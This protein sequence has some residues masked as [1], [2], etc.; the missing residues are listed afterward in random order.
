[1]PAPAPSPPVGP[2]GPPG[3]IPLI[4]S[5]WLAGGSGPS[6][7]STSAARAGPSAG[8]PRPCRFADLPLMAERV[9]DPPDAPAVLVLHRRLCSSARCQ[10]H[11][12]HRVRI[13][14]DEQ[15][16]ARPATDRPGAEAT[17]ARRWRANPER[18]IA[19]PELGDDVIT[20]ADAVQDPSAERRPVEVHRLGGRLNPQLRL[21][22]HHDRN[23]ARR[24][25]PQVLA[26]A[27]SRRGQLSVVMAPC[28]GSLPAGSP[29]TGTGRPP[30]G[31]P[32]TPARA[33][34]QT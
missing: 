20:V 32:P 29:C 3:P 26:T 34:A 13:V 1:M 16:P 10:R 2:L 11:P 17:H 5:Q 23:C 28:P 18:S 7:R 22:A 6:P 33:G 9:N 15:R 8:R 14:H 27:R 12:H 25:S 24:P 30:V 19:D 21:N 31:S 4:P